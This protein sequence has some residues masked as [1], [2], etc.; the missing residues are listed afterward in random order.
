[1]RHSRAL[2]L[3]VHVL[4]RSEE[5]CAQETY[6]EDPFL[7]GRLAASFV[8]GVQGDR[9]HPFLKAAHLHSS[10]QNILNTHDRRNRCPKAA[11]AHG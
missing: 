4:A 1:M 10:L 6:G 7:T 11:H 8:R 5:V 9:E 3:V 2:V